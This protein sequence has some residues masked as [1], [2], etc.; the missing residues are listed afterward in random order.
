MSQI[1]KEEG[2]KQILQSKRWYGKQSHITV[3][4]L[5]SNT[6][7][8]VHAINISYNILHIPR[9]FPVRSILASLACP[10]TDRLIAVK[11][12]V[13]KLKSAKLRLDSSFSS[14]RTSITSA[15]ASRR[16]TC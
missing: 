16:K 1:I 9:K 3:A 4:Y 2:S 12:E 13:F 7:A 8:R 10:A 6:H 5:I 14:L 11:C 15:R